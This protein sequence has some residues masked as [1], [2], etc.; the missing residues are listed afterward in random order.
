VTSSICRAFLLPLVL[1]CSLPTNPARAAETRTTQWP[2]SATVEIRVTDATGAAVDRAEVIIESPGGA[3]AV[4]PSGGS[5]VHRVQLGAGR[6]VIT[7]V[8]P[9]FE[10]VTREVTVAASSPLAVDVVLNP[11]GLSE[12][13]TV[14]G[15]TRF[16]GPPPVSGARMP[17]AT[18]DL[19]QSVE[20]VS[21]A[22]LQTQAALSM[23]EALLNVTGVTPQLGEGRR[24][25][26][27]LRGFS[28]VNDQYIDGVRDDARYYRDLSNLETVEVVKGAASALYGRGSTGGLINRITKK[29]LFGQSVTDISVTTG[30]YDRRRVQA[31]LGRSFANDRLAFRLTGAYENSG[32]HRPEYSLE[33]VAAAPSLAWRSA[34]GTEV[35]VQ[36]EFLDDSRV[37][38]RGIPS[39]NGEPVHDARDVY[40]GT[41]DEDFV[42]NRVTSQAIT[43]QQRL[44]TGWQLRNVFRH[45]WY[46]TEFSNTQPGTTR[47]VAG[48]IVAARTQYNVD[49]TQ[50]NLFNQTELLTTGVLG[51]LAHTT[52]VG[53]ELGQEK[54]RTQRFNGTAPDVDVLIPVLGRPAYAATPGTN[55]AFTGDIAA[56]YIQEQLVVGRWRGL[57]GGRFDHF[58][59]RLDD[60]N[61]A[62]VDLSRVD[63]V[64]S[65]RAGLVY[66]TTPWSSLYASYSR[67]FQPSGE[68]L[69]LA[70]NTRELK[71]EDTLSYEVGAKSDLFGDRV[72][73]GAALFR[74]DRRNVRTRD[75]ID[76]NRL[77]L[78]GRQRSEG[79]ELNAS[80]RLLAGW[81][82]RGGITFLDPKILESNDVSSGVPVAGNRIGSTATRTANL[83][84]TYSMRNGV[85]VGGGLFHVGD[86]YTSNDN[87]VRLD[88]YTRVDAMAAYRLGRYEVALNLKNL[89][90]TDYYESSNGNT[91]I[92]PAAGINGLVSIRYRW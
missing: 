36:A 67:S 55:N 64:F 50:R 27:A 88:G 71:P 34:R 51:P 43:L 23:Q 15:A 19:P 58:D 1:S 59:Q 3:R 74:L 92:M 54:T 81:D 11:A 10:P 45:T 2:T 41:P 47:L 66:R 32:S 82:L 22:V 29:P 83:W 89:L 35:I 62:N 72:S 18:L 14:T 48:R 87:L 37:P 20:V 9:G 53:V 30:S 69:S 38:D 5:G 33:R 31:D 75:P 78:V 70:V 57:V 16:E 46:D 7:V 77:V 65:P 79:V 17:I 40:F 49:A 56:A 6:H 44:G 60:L 25:Q 21:Q 4:A 68:G 85:T 90:D 63:R 28:A 91:Q 73:L 26:V 86:W 12:Q 39:F 8:K 52:L 80:G 13:I 84:S 24:D 76:P 42:D 61:P